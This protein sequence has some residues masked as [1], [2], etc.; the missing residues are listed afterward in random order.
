MSIKCDTWLLET[1]AALCWFTLDKLKKID[2][3]YL[4]EK[5]VS[6]NTTLSYSCGGEVDLLFSALEVT[7]ARSESGHLHHQ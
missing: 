3:F 2:S 4:R 7:V 1:A 6:Y 5:T